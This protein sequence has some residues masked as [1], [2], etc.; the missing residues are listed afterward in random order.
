MDERT[1]EIIEATANRTAQAMVAQK[2]YKKT[3][4]QRTEALLR[5]YPSMCKAK[6][7]PRTEKMVA[8]IDEALEDIQ[9]DPYYRIIPLFYFDGETREN[10]ASMLASTVRTVG[11][12]KRRLVN[13]LKIRLFSDQCIYEILVGEDTT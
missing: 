7:Q 4:Y 12:N 5:C 3:A 11:R 6:G 10:I 9:A 8:K 2:S 1:L 13:E